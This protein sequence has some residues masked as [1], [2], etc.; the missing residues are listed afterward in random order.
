MAEGRTHSALDALLGASPRRVMRHWVSLLLLAIAALGSVIFFVRFVTGDDSPYYSAAIERGDFVP[1]VSE[2]SIVR[3]AGEVMVRA[4]IDGRVTWVLGDP[5]G[6]VEKGTLLARIDPGQ[7]ASDVAVANA[8]LDAANAGLESAEI[9]SRETAARLARFES[10]W[11]KSQGRAPSINELESARADAERAR[12][13]VQSAA[14]RR[15]AAKAQLRKARSLKG[16]DEIRAPVTGIVVMRHARL[17]QT[18]MDGQTLFTIAPPSDPLIVEAPLNA[19]TDTP[20][21]AGA[22]AH[23]RLEAMPDKAFSATLTRILVPLAPQTGPHRAV[24]TIESADPKV[25]PGMPA[26]VE[27]NLDERKGVLLVP[28]AALKFEPSETRTGGQRR[29]RIY[30]LTRDGEPKRVYVT[31]GGSDGTRTEVF[32]TGIRPGDQVIT[33]W[34]NAASRR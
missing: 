27:M 15:D 33:G 25:H 1:L 12:L 16:K 14:A 6:H 2:R 8:D 29:P 21:R 3:S 9:S 32:A 24:F 13:S 19:R 18:V 4:Q 22:R 34:R 23:L 10:V 17:G 31:T 7:L 30:L 20:M 5:G 26:T 11:R 28:D